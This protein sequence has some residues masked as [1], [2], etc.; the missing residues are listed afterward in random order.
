IVSSC[1]VLLMLETTFEAVKQLKKL[2]ALYDA[3]TQLTKKNV[4]DVCAN[5]LLPLVF[6]QVC[7]EEEICN[8]FSTVVKA[9]TTVLEGSRWDLLPLRDSKARTSVDQVR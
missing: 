3:N 6:Y 5:S 1:I 8:V 9:F 4:E 7:Q 2:M